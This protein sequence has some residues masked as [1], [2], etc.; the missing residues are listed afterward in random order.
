MAL[1]LKQLK[2]DKEALEKQFQLAILSNPNVQRLQ[3]AI[4]YIDTCIK[5]LEDK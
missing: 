2:A 3:G 5:R 4:N 1:S